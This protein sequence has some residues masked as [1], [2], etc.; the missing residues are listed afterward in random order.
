[1]RCASATIC[2][3]LTGSPARLPLHDL[4][5]RECKALDTNV[6]DHNRFGFPGGRALDSSPRARFESATARRLGERP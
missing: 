6:V 3:S 1:M 5:V 2:A 4:R